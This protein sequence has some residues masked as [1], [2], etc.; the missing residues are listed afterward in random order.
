MKIAANFICKGNGTSKVLRHARVH[1][2]SWYRRNQNNTALSM[3]EAGR[4]APGYS[5]N[6]FGSKIFDDDIIAAISDIRNEEFTQIAGGYKKL[7]H[8]LFRKSRYYSK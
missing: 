1:R 8:Y 3:G 2:T 5:Y 7:K 4:P 6:K